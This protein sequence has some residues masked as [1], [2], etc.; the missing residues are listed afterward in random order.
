MSLIKDVDLF[1]NKISIFINV[2]QKNMNEETF[3]LRMY[4]AVF[5]RMLQVRSPRIIQNDSTSHALVLI[6]E[7]LNAATGTVYVYCMKLDE[8]VWGNVRVLAALTS[9]LNRGVKFNVLTREKVSNENPAYKV[10]TEKQASVSVAESSPAAENFIVVDERA[11]RLELDTG[12]RKG[13]A[14]ANSSLNAMALIDIYRKME[15][16]GSAASK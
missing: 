6:E 8:K 5:Q 4:R 3:D 7:L 1:L 13:F 16:V 2:S 11:F 15:G 12:D 14:C 9:A 10:L